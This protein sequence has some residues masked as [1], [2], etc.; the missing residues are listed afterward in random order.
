MCALG[1]P[2]AE[3]ARDHRGVEDEPM[4]RSRFIALVAALS[5]GSVAIGVAAP[6]PAPPPTPFVPEVIYPYKGTNYTDLRLSNA[7]G[8]AAALIHRGQLQATSYDLAPPNLR[9]AVYVEVE[10]VDVKYLELRSWTASASTGAI[11]MGPARTLD[12]A[13]SILFTDFSPTGDRIAYASSAVQNVY[14]LKTVDVAS[15]IVTTVAVGVSPSTLRWSGDGSSLYYVVR[16][17]IDGVSSQAAYRQPISGGPRMLMFREATIEPWDISR[18]GTDG[19]IFPYWRPGWSDIAMG[20][21]DGARVTTIPSIT[22]SSPHYSCGND[23]LIY[24]SS[25][26]GNPGPVKIYSFA[27]Q[28]NVVFS[29]DQK[30]YQAD[31]MP[32]G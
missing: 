11:T 15:G 2:L 20:K 32:C 13:R 9:M 16:E 5:L 27:T 31:F 17:T 25:T 19:L 4:N 28:S 30:I 23:R 10:S 14:D 26:N 22:G 29:R 8:T 6:R 7:A 3:R 12:S 18:D 1:P 21:W 24:R